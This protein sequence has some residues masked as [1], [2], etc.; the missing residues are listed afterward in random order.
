MRNCL[1]PYNFDGPTKLFQVLMIVM[2]FLVLLGAFTSYLWYYREYGKLARYFLVNMFRFPSS[3]RLMILLYGVKPFL[4]G[5]IHA[6]MFYHWPTQIWLLFATELFIFFM[7]LLFEF[8]F[9]NHR[10]KPVFMMDATYSGCLIILNLLFLFKYR[11]YKGDM[12]MENLLEEMIIVIV[13]YMVILLLLKFVWETFPWSFLFNLFCRKTIKKRRKIKER[14]V[15]NDKKREEERNRGTNR[16]AQRLELE[17]I[18]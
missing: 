12:E 18:E 17:V 13:F 2:F 16:R 1:T 11:F 3:Y 9:D 15:E 14:K 5:S 4:K 8:I 6:L 10:S 7:M